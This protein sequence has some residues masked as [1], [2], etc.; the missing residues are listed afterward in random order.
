MP[1]VALVDAFG[2]IDDTTKRL[3][4]Q[5]IL[6][7]LFRSIIAV[8]PEDL[9]P[10]V[11]LSCNK[12]APSFEGIELGIGDSL[13]IKAICGAYGRSN[14]SVKAQ[15]DD[16]GDLG[17]VAEK[18]K[19]NQRSLFG[20]KPKALTL[21]GVYTNL[22]SIAKMTGNKSQDKKVGM[23]KKMLVACTPLEARYV[24]RALQGKLR[25]GLAQQTVLI[26]VAHAF[27]CGTD[28]EYEEAVEIVKQAHSE[29]PTFGEIIP[30][31]LEHG[32]RKL[33][34]VCH[35]RP[36]IPV[37]PM[38]AKPTKG[39]TEVLD[40]FSGVKFTCEYK[41]D[42]ERA[43]IHMLEN[44]EIHVYSRNGE[45]NT[46]KYPDVI[47]TMPAAIA[48]DAPMTSFIIDSEVVAYDLKKKCLLPFQILSTRAQ[49][50]QH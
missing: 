45:D 49:G 28:V 37:N 39:V 21:R 16:E 22:M 30:A 33:A 46:T 15:L 41:Y 18:S 5:K 36:G 32:L 26:S 31:L 13:L 50:R 38:L 17:L 19:K 6:T 43:Q 40:K 29:L 35:L 12:L 8:S 48:G 27:A 23:I 2:K 14:K 4:I 20:F 10:S 9:L 7:K 34:S 25:I 3:A 47:K 42:G 1:Y 44:G 24:V 11:Y